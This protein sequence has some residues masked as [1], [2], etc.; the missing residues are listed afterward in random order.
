MSQLNIIILSNLIDDHQLVSLTSEQNPNSNQARQ[1]LLDIRANGGDHTQRWERSEDIVALCVPNRSENKRGMEIVAITGLREAFLPREV[2]LRLDVFIEELAEGTSDLPGENQ[3]RWPE[4]RSQ[5]IGTTQHRRSPI[6]DQFEEELQAYLRH[7]QAPSRTPSPSPSPSPSSEPRLA[8]PSTKALSLLGALVLIA[9]IWWIAPRSDQPSHDATGA[10]IELIERG[11]SATKE[12]RNRSQGMSHERP[13]QE[14]RESTHHPVHDPATP[15]SAQDVSQAK[16][17]MQQVLKTAPK[18]VDPAT[19]ERLLELLNRPGVLPELKRAEP[20]IV[21]ELSKHLKRL[22]QPQLGSPRPERNAP[23]PSIPHETSPKVGP[24][25]SHPSQRP[26]SQRPP[27]K[28]TSS[29]PPL[30]EKTAQPKGAL[31]EPQVTSDHLLCPS[32]KKINQHLSWDDLCWLHE[33]LREVRSHFSPD[34]GPRTGY[35]FHKLGALVEGGVTQGIEQQAIE[36]MNTPDCGWFHQIASVVSLR[37]ALHQNEDLGY[38]PEAYKRL[39]RISQSRCSLKDNYLLTLHVLSLTQNE[40]TPATE[41]SAQLPNHSY[42]FNRALSVRIESDQAM[43]EEVKATIYTEDR[44]TLI[45][46]F[47]QAGRVKTLEK[48]DAGFFSRK[49]KLLYKDL[50]A[51]WSFEKQTQKE[52]QVSFQLTF[53]RDEVEEFLEAL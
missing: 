30:S 14:R 41:A 10:L 28:S 6:L 3:A 39:Q 42:A 33:H 20:Q 13:T 22:P 23:R 43:G 32:S 44:G 40:V 11:P 53:S 5:V 15:A 9:L 19:L 46:T 4:K 50:S 18:G 25:Q 48:K 36:A 26:P 2:V 27:S 12:D 8:L 29:T 51:R 1:I 49:P 52:L 17:V 47:D 16:E 37:G 38:L 45:L 21:S 31:N 7:L 24:L 35:P 34:W